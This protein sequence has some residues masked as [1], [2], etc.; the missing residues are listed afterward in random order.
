[1]EKL[2]D[3]TYFGIP[4][5]KLPLDLL[6]E[7]ILDL[8]KD[9]KYKNSDG[10]RALRDQ[11]DQ[12]GARYERVVNKLFEYYQE[13]ESKFITIDPEG[14]ADILEFIA[15]ELKILDTF[16]NAIRSWLV[17]GSSNLDI[18]V[19]IQHILKCRT[20]EQFK[21]IADEIGG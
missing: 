5:N 18:H 2:K 20:A 12:L 4:I 7:F 9:K 21:T 19:T 8:L 17:E 1:M 10:E 14:N 13:N 6:E 15:S 11:L 16:R 3:F